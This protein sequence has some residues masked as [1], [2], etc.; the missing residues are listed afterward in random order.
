MLVWFSFFFFHQ[1]SRWMSLLLFRWSVSLFYF[2][3]DENT[4]IIQQV[5]RREFIH[6]LSHH[7]EIF[8]TIFFIVHFTSNTHTEKK[9]FRW[10][11]IFRCHFSALCTLLH[12][13][14]RLMGHICYVFI[15]KKKFH[16]IQVNYR[17]SLHLFLY[18]Q[19]AK[20][21]TLLLLLLLLAISSSSSISYLNFTKRIK[22]TNDIC[23][24]NDDEPKKKDMN[25]SP[26]VFIELKNGWNN[27]QTYWWIPPPE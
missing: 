1:I 23:C 2:I 13:Y 16:H 5:K 25:I 15:K 26:Y 27:K 9:N 24:I 8:I 18:F 7:S 17:C 6:S 19:M 20:K 14:L 22:K 11:F 12:V 4:I 21:T 3:F 10:P